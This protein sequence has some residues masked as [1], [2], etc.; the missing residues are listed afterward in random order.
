MSE[1]VSFKCQIP[2]EGKV[3]VF[4]GDFRQCLPVI[5][6]G[7]R[8]EI[9]DSCIKQ[10]YL[11]SNFSRLPLEANMRCSDIDYCEWLL[12][13]GELTNEHNLGEDVIEIPSELLCTQSIVIDIFGHQ[14]SIDI[15]NTK[16]IERLASHAILCPKNDDV[17][18]LNSEIM[19]RI[20]GEDTVYKSDDT[21][22][23][24]EDDQRENYPVEFL[25]SLSPSGMPL[26]RLRLKI[27]AIV[28]L[29]RN[30]NTKKALCNGTRLIVT[31][32]LPNVIATKVITG[33]AAGDDVFIPRIDL[34]P[35]EIKL[36]FR[37][38]RRQF[39]IK[40]AFAMTINKS[41]GQSLKKVGIYLP[42]P[43]FGHGQLYVAFSRVKE[44]TGVKV[45]VINTPSQ[46]RLLPDS[47]K[48]F[49]K[50]IVYKN[51]LLAFTM[52]INKAQGQTL[53]TRACVYARTT[54]YVAFS[55]V[56]TL[57]SIHVKMTH[58][59]CSFRFQSSIHSEEAS[60]FTKVGFCYDYK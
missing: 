21:V 33:S 58:I 12:G 16:S 37:L 57:D 52:T 8:T 6:N 28:M 24:D 43:V 36:P 22:V 35:S 11:W 15:T 23:T 5:P 55:S 13:N 30:L 31:N 2:F 10:S 4:G 9:V 46:G 25:N 7:T 39:P 18:L 19:D 27:G 44:K 48:V 47:D 40:L 26:H 50:N 60:V 17:D 49:T 29:L 20:T 56:R 34:C 59:F 54:L 3:I 14:I 41:Q 1:S 53:A 38:K 51:I 32:L 45:Q 42:Q